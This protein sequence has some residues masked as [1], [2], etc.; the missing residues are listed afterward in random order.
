MLGTSG[1]FSITDFSFAARQRHRLDIRDSLLAIYLGYSARNAF[2][3]RVRCRQISAGHCHC[4]WLESFWGHC[5][6]FTPAPAEL[7]WRLG[8]TYITDLRP[9]P[10]AMAYRVFIIIIDYYH[11]LWC[12]WRTLPGLRLN[13]LKSKCYSWTGWI[14]EWI[15]Q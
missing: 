6:W 5:H 2:V 4:H 15:N 11:I 1:D 7:C 12:S 14:E 9:G 8:Y 10:V 13:W 3:L